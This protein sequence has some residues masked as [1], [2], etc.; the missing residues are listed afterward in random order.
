MKRIIEYDKEISALKLKIT[1]LKEI[2][3]EYPKMNESVQA[4]EGKLREIENA[5]D[6]MIAEQ[7]SRLKQAPAALKEI[8]QMRYVDGLNFKEIA[9]RMNYSESNIHKLHRKLKKWQG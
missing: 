3:A 6:S 8:F 2:A 1:A 9:G 5:R 7:Q 4:T